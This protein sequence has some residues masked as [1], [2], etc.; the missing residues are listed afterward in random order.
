[1]PSFSEVFFFFF[2][3]FSFPFFFL[4][5][6]VGGVGFGFLV[7]VGQFVLLVFFVVCFVLSRRYQFVYGRFSLMFILSM[8]LLLK[9]SI[10]DSCVVQSLPGRRP[11]VLVIFGSS[12]RLKLNW[13]ISRWLLASELMVSLGV[14]VG[15]I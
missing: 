12:R 4:F 5:F 9:A 2:F 14:T 13:L 10:S 15:E 8:E 6:L 7:L 1:M 11:L 3:F